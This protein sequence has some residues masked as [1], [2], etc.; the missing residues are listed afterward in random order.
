MQEEKKGREK[1]PASVKGVLVERQ[2]LN[3]SKITELLE[4]A[5]EL[6]K[7]YTDY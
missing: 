6:D 7:R 3:E 1:N 5:E 4:K 2:P